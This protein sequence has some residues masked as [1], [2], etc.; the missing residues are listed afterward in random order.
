MPPP[1][2]RDNHGY[3]RQYP[4]LPLAASGGL[5]GMR[6]Q[7]ECSRSPCDHPAVGLQAGLSLQPVVYLQRA[8]N[9]EA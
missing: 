1:V 5:S 8:A 4:L 6:C 2:M 9:S 3:H 7:K